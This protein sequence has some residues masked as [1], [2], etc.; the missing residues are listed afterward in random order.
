[1]MRPSLAL[2]SQSYMWQHGPRWCGITQPSCGMHLSCDLRSLLP[3]ALLSSIGIHESEPICLPLGW[4]AT[5]HDLALSFSSLFFFPRSLHMPDIPMPK[6]HPCEEVWVSTMRCKFQNPLSMQRFVSNG[7]H[8]L[9]KGSEDKSGGK[10]GAEACAPHLF[11]SYLHCRLCTCSRG[12][13]LRYWTRCNVA[14]DFAVTPKI[15]CAS[16]KWLT[17][18]LSGQACFLIH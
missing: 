12:A 6:P 10:W 3:P 9:G 18:A 13:C 8:V 4:P 17:V 11:P 16:R 7:G 15:A 2:Y 1:M 5:C 14:S